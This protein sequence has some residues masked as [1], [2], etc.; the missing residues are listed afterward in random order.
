MALT[1]HQ[2]GPNHVRFL[3]RIFKGIPNFAAVT[4]RWRSLGKAPDGEYF[5]DVKSAEFPAN[6]PVRL[7]IK[8]VK[9]KGTETV[10]YELDCKGRLI[11]GMSS[12]TYDTNGKVV[13]SSDVSSGWQRVVPDSIGEQ[14]LNGACSSIR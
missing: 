4:D 2:F 6:E 10:A 3:N 8:T 1:P 7:W 5:L 9:K 11:N 12:I 13:N 14:L